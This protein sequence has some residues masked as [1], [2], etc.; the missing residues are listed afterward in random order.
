MKISSI[1]NVVKN[2]L[3]VG[4]ILIVSAIVLFSAYWAMEKF[5]QSSK[6]KP[7]KIL[8]QSSA[9]KQGFS[10]ELEG[11][12]VRSINF[13]KKV[14]ETDCPE[15]LPKFNVEVEQPKILKDGDRGSFV[16]MKSAFPSLFPEG[17]GY[18]YNLQCVEGYL[19]KDNSDGSKSLFKSFYKFTYEYCLPEDEESIG[20]KLTGLC[21]TDR[22]MGNSKLF[23]GDCKTRFSGWLVQSNE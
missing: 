3:S 10:D 15:G 17:I 11:F 4:L 23:A 7:Y 18:T 16:M 12:K 5:K 14:C 20:N 21:F 6:D 19:R 8:L 9:Q 13:Q 1:V 2:L 22:V